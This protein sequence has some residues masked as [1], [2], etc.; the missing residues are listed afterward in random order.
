MFFILQE[1]PKVV[2]SHELDIKGSWTITPLLIYLS[3]KFPNTKWFFFCLENTVIQL[4][5]LLNVL[6]KFD[7]SQVSCIFVVFFK[8]KIRFILNNLFTQ[9]IWIGHA[10]YDHEPTII[11]HFAKNIKKFKYPLMATGFGM[12]FNLVNRYI[13]LILFVK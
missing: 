6:G 5:K 9:N 4:A 3:D 13:L 2:L 10:L 1:S 11:H 7:A 12:T 8:K